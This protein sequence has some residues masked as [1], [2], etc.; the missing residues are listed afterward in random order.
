MK[1]NL[2]YYIHPTKVSIF[3]QSNFIVNPQIDLSSHL[4]YPLTP[5][6][7][8]GTNN[9]H[10]IV[11]PQFPSLHSP[12]T[13]PTTHLMMNMLTPPNSPYF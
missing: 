4:P 6:Y 8:E 2:H 12:R 1:P 10:H 3:F 11:P 5:Q 7:M 13:Q 9:Y